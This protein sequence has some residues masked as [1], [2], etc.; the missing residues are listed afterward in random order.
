[1]LAYEL[2]PATLRPGQLLTITLYWQATRVLEQDAQVSLQVFLNNNKRVALANGPPLDK[3]RP[4]SSWHPGEVLRD[5]WTLDLPA[6]IPAPALL[7]LD[8]SLFLPKTLVPLPVQNSAGEDIPG[9]IAAVRLEP[10]AWPRYQGDQPLDFVFGEAIGLIGY[11]ARPNL[12]RNKLDVTLYWNTLASPPAGDSLTAFLHLL[13]PEGE[14]AAQSDV[15]PAW[16]LF[17]TTAWR[18]GDVVLSWHQLDLPQDAPEKNYMLLA[19]LYRPADGTRL[20]GR[21]GGDEPLPND[22]APLGAV[23]LP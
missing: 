5:T 11:E 20:A 10:K 22:A 13:D 16:G 18:P 9:A 12:E 19:G 15:L 21:T 6:D 17:P 23:S 8:A 4:T 1:L 3:L 2:R 14:L 7:R